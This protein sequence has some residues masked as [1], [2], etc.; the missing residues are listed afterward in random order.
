MILGKKLN[1]KMPKIA[2]ETDCNGHGTDERYEFSH[3]I[4]VVTKYEKIILLIDLDAEF[5][6]KLLF[7]DFLP[8]II[9]GAGNCESL[10]LRVK[11]LCLKY[12]GTHGIFC[13]ILL[14]CVRYRLM[15]R[16]SHANSTTQRVDRDD[17]WHDKNVV[18]FQYD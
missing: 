10:I 1:M 14:S 13:N 17:L 8:K 15:M 7:E 4:S 3:Q 6:V 18:H 2:S 16:T 11:F 9:R 12:G 5:H